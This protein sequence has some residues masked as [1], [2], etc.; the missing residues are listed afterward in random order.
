M[1]AP[2][3]TGAY[4]CGKCFTDPMQTL[5]HF[6]SL[7]PRSA[8]LQHYLREGENESKSIRHK[9]TRRS[10]MIDIRWSSRLKHL[11]LLDRRFTTHNVIFLTVCKTWV[12]FSL[13]PLMGFVYISW[14]KMEGTNVGLRRS[15]N[16]NLECRVLLG[17]QSRYHPHSY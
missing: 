17:G 10:D 1:V 14:S 6:L 15:R 13:F 11:T 5:V 8:S 3:P 7:H 2:I 16:S 9:P 4:S 12:I